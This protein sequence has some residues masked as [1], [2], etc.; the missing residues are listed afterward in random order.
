MAMEGLRLC[1]SWFFM[2]CI[3]L[4]ALATG[5]ETRTSQN[6]NKCTYA[7]TIE[8]TCTD[9]AETSDHV[10]IRFGDTNS[11]DIVVRRLNAKRFHTLDPLQPADS[12]DDVPRKPFRA[13]AVDEFHVAGE[14][15][16]S[17][18]CYLYLKLAG[19][20][21]WRPGFAKVEVLGGPHLSSEYFYFRRYLPRRVWHGS[22]SCEK[23]VTPIG[24]KSKRKVFATKRFVV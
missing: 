1:N 17:A 24:I 23:E 10:A 9:G 2:S 5:N 19:S 12:L 6:K 16:E 15:V 13:C 22:D 14:C 11:T 4:F 3:L 7:I 18:V 20:D 8:T 21:D